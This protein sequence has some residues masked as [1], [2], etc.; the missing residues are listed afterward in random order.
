MP[1]LTLTMAIFLTG[2]GTLPS[3][4]HSKADE[5]KITKAKEAITA[6]NTTAPALYKAMQANLDAFA[7]EEDRVI[8][9]YADTAA[10]AGYAY[11]NVGTI[12]TSLK[13]LNKDIENFLTQELPAQILTI[14]G[15]SD[16]AKQ[17]IAAAKDPIAKT[18]ELIKRKKA[19]ITALNSSIALLRTAIVESP[20]LQKAAKSA[21]ASTDEKDTLS[22]AAE[23]LQTLGDK[24]I[25][26][27]D[28]D[29]KTQTQKASKV[30]EAMF[31]RASGGEAVA[32]IPHTPGI[33]LVILSLALDL[34]QYD[35]DQAKAELG[36]VASVKEMLED[37][38]T[39]AVVAGELLK[40]AR[41][42]FDDYGDKSVSVTSLM[43][44]SSIAMRKALGKGIQIDTDHNK[45]RTTLVA[46]R[47]LAVAQSNFRR[48]QALMKVALARLDHQRS[49]VHSSFNDSR[50][51]A[52]ISRSV[53]GLHAYHSG[54]FTPEHAAQILR[55]AQVVALGSIAEQL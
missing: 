11:D 41:E 36:Y 24:E 14:N 4:M 31:R 45:L 32:V 10:M 17:A 43:A 5:E 13:K 3:H 47:K 48:S 15:I 55:L 38:Y 7:K 28:G 33:D 54:G 40:D 26:F 25:T 42:T 37:C 53:E 9:E 39:R 18:N 29:G 20:N 1:I 2:C 30:A 16:S 12:E 49:I 21:S 50:R 19:D 46:V 22:E 6:H 8:N 35:R 52:V 23:Q 51:R 44:T 34:L 27:V